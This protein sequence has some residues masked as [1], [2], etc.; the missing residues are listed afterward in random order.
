MFGT[1]GNVIILI[2]IISNKDMRTVPNMYIINLVISGLFILALYF[3][4]LC[5]YRITDTLVLPDF[6]IA[7]LTFCSQM[8][9]GLSAYS[10][11]MLSFQRYRVTMN[12]VYVR[13]PSQLTWRIAVAELGKMWI[14]AALFSL[15]STIIYFL[16]QK[17]VIFE[18][19][20]YVKY[21][22]LF[23]LLV[24]CVFPLCVIVF[25]HI[26]THRHLVESP[27]STSEGKEHPQMSA[28]VVLGLTVVFMF[29]YVPYYALYTYIYFN[30]DFSFE[31]RFYYMLFLFAVLYYLV[32][33]NACLNPVALFCTSALFR[34]HLKRYLNC[35]CK[36]NSPP[37]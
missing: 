12:H 20:T 28:K 13:V 4:L 14:V 32:S 15:P 8:A 10:V 24:T 2:I 36:A 29:S 3:S 18:G 30:L 21:V 6:F 31:N 16:I 5:A 35:S 26:M 9:K 19:V 37:Y 33:I 7:L 11:A 23:E 25:S 34:K 17:N 22:V 27:R 1:T